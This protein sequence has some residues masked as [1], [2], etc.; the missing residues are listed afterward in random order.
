MGEA[1]RRLAA[2]GDERAGRLEGWVREGQS[3]GKSVAALQGS[4]IIRASETGIL[5]L[6]KSGE[7]HR[8]IQARNIWDGGDLPGEPTLANFDCQDLGLLLGGLLSNRYWNDIHGFLTEQTHLPRFITILYDYLGKEGQDEH[9]ELLDAVTRHCTRNEG[10]FHSLA[11]DIGLA[12]N[13]LLHSHS[14]DDA[15]RSTLRRLVEKVEPLLG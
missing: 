2:K 3:L 14:V 15:V 5:S 13:R 4:A 8:L 11:R 7:I 6:S 10:N 1:V 9:T 12:S